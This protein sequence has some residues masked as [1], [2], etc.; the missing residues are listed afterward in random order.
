MVGFL[1]NYEGDF[2]H[3]VNTRNLTKLSDDAKVRKQQ[4]RLSKNYDANNGTQHTQEE[5]I[6]GYFN[7]LRKD[8]KEKLYELYKLDF[9]MF[10]YD[11]N[12]FL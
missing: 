9:D 12:K 7:A 10:G 5:R 6:N 4:K 11:V 1:E 3:L 8:I 2:L